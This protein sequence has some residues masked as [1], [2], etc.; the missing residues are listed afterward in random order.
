M[1][2]SIRSV[3]IWK[4]APWSPAHPILYSSTHPAHPTRHPEQPRG[5]WS[6]A[7]HGERGISGKMAPT[8]GGRFIE[9]L[10]RQIR[11]PVRKL[12]IHPS[13]LWFRRIMEMVL[14]AT[15]LILTA[16]GQK[17]H[18]KIVVTFVAHRAKFGRSVSAQVSD[19]GS[20]GAQ[21]VSPKVSPEESRKG[22]TKK[23]AVSP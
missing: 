16:N 14:P 6:I 20:A 13:A 9:G 7:L 21:K 1:N 18:L 15:R 12:P 3:R 19:S 5:R 17:P 8:Q 10:C 11:I 4:S 23:P 2:V 22:V